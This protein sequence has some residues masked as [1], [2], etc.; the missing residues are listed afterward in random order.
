MG[1]PIGQNDFVSCFLEQLKGNQ[2]CFTEKN[3][4]LPSSQ[5][6][7]LLLCYCAVPHAFYLLRC[8][9]TQSPGFLNFIEFRDNLHRH[10]FCTLF[11][12]LNPLTLCQSNQLQLPI[13]FGGMGVLSL[14]VIAPAAFLAASSWAPKERLLR[15]PD[16]FSLQPLNA[17]NERLLEIS[18]VQQSMIQ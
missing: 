12:I 4:G 13:P 2:Q 3:I 5:V 11:D 10:C 17:Q 9:L 6:A 15:A 7:S 16:A 8:F 14:Q 1:V 18:W